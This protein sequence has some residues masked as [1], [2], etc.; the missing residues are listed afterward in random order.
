MIF[1]LQTMWILDQEQNDQ[2]VDDPDPCSTQTKTIQ[3]QGRP[4]DKPFLHA[5]SSTLIKRIKTTTKRTK[6]YP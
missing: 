2:L 3:V 4:T 5:S 6:N 1:R